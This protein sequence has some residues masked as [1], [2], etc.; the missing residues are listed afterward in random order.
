MRGLVRTTSHLLLHF[1]LSFFL[2][3]RSTVTAQSPHPKVK[4]VS[5]R[6]PTHVQQHPATVSTGRRVAG[7]LCIVVAVIL[8]LPTLCF[9]ALGCYSAFVEE[10]SRPPVVIEAALWLACT[11]S[12]LFLYF[13]GSELSPF[14][15]QT[16]RVLATLALCGLVLIPTGAWAHN[17]VDPRFILDSEDRWAS[18][19]GDIGM[20]VFAVGVLLGHI[21]RWLRSPA[22]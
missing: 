18:G 10:S 8:S 11:V 12:G 6:P 3:T 14:E 9:L 5:A 17:W 2:R 21:G 19:Y 20:T 4:P 1:F 16:R 13:V 7:V 15:G 22:R